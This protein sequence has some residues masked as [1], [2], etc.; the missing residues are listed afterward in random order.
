MRG[1]NAS[2]ISL[3]CFLLCFVDFE[4]LGVYQAS[5]STLPKRVVHPQSGSGANIMRQ[6]FAPKAQS[7]GQRDAHPSN[8]TRPSS[9]LSLN[10]QLSSMKHNIQPIC[11]KASTQRRLSAE[12]L[13]V[14]GSS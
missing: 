10:P 11:L 13:R 7:G 2:E 9:L 3:H 5:K 6:P 8:H 12:G 4:K 1:M 14:S